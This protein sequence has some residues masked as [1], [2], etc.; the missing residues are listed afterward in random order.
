[1]QRF[2]QRHRHL[3][4]VFLIQDGDPSH[5]ATATLVVCQSCFDGINRP[6]SVT[7]VVGRQRRL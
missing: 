7:S 3:R 2:R 6:N 1:L 5:T 4:G